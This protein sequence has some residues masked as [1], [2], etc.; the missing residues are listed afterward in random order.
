VVSKF[1][2]FGHPHFH[3]RYRDQDLSRSSHNLVRAQEVASEACA[4]ALKRTYVRVCIPLG[5][6]GNG[7][8]KLGLPP[9]FIRIF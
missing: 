8:A 9:S 7:S 2:I 5:L 1:G 3:H 4:H 6:G